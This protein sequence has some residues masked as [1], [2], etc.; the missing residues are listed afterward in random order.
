MP[1]IRPIRFSALNALNPLHQEKERGEYHDRQADVDHVGHGV[2]PCVA[3]LRGHGTSGIGRKC[4]P[5]RDPCRGVMIPNRTHAA[6]AGALAVSVAGGW[7]MSL[8]PG[9]SLYTTELCVAAHR[10]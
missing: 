4:S 5:M 10:T 6:A 9:G 1:A 7:P 2:L 8:P 3:C